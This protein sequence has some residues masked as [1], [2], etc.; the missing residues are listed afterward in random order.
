L[1][2]VLCIVQSVTLAVISVT[3][4]KLVFLWQLGVTA[5]DIVLMAAMKF[6]AVAVVSI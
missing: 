3:T 4:V 5:T 2:D 1:Y 6:R